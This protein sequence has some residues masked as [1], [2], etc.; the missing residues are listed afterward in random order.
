MSFQIDTALVQTYK[1]NIELQFQQQ[2]SRLRSTVRNETQNSEY[3]YYDRIGPVDATEVTTRHADTPLSNTQH[4]RRRIGLK[5]Y[6]WADLIDNPDKL[7]M[8][9]DPTSAYVQNAA[10]ALGRKMDDAIIAA[11]TGAA[12]AG[13][14]GSTTINFPS[15]QTIA[16]NYVESGASAVS[17]LTIAKLRRA[18]YLIDSKEAAADNEILTC[19]IS[20]SQLQ[21]LLRTTEVTS[22]DYNSV[23]ALVAGQ[24]DTFL[25]FKFARTERLKKTG[26]SRSVLVYPQSGITLAVAADISVDVTKRPDKRNSWQVYATASFGASRM[27]EEK[28]VE[29]L[30]DETV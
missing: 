8:L 29:I 27:W 19:V 2:G 14:T 10:F 17:N 23:K 3:D 28:V 12:S 21:S 15:S 30:C 18:K 4:D 1:A 20:A 13:K 22:A 16:V 24:L 26:N 7:R 5:F 6:D 11:A 9:T 25:G